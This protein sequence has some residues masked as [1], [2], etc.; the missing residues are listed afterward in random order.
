MKDNF[1]DYYLT[2]FG[3]LE[4]IHSVISIIDFIS[5]INFDYRIHENYFMATFSSFLNI[6][7]IE[8]LVRGFKHDFVLTEM[9][10]KFSFN[11]SDKETEDEMFGLLNTDEKYKSEDITNKLIQDILDDKNESNND[12][13]LKNFS[14][15]SRRVSTRQKRLKSEYYKNLT[16]KEKEEMVNNI[17]DKGFDNISDYDR[18]VLSI[19]SNTE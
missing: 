2:M 4:E 11:F 19:I 5:E 12:S 16:K 10:S 6:K 3:D 1:R 7:E 14:R 9:D 18:R 15:K 13:L 8:D 17:L